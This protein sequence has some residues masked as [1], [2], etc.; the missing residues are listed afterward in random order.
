VH[1]ATFTKDYTH[2]IKS[3][4]GFSNEIDKAIVEATDLTK[5]LNKYVTLVMD[6]MYFKSDS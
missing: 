5:N 1:K 2:Y 3:E 4:G 6:E